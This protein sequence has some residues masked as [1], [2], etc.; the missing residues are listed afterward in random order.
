MSPA[1]KISV[2]RSSFKKGALSTADTA[3]GAKGKSIQF[4]EDGEQE[5]VGGEK[6][7]VHSF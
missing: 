6:G 1:T 2:R 4:K 3:K 5:D 7:Y